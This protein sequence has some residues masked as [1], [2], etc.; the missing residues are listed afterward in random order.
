MTARADDLPPLHP[1][2][3]DRVESSRCPEC[4]TNGVR[5]RV[6]V[7]PFEI[8]ACPACE[9]EAVQNGGQL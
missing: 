4:G 5:V 7:W 2:I 3:H 1:R 8:W 9:P 6:L